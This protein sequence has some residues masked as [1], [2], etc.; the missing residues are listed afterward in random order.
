MCFRPSGILPV[1]DIFDAHAYPAPEIDF[2]YPG[3]NDYVKVIGEFGG[4]GWPVDGH[5][6]GDQKKKKFVY[7]EMPKTLAEY[8]ARYEKTLADLVALKAR[9]V[10][11]GVYTQTTDVE[12]EI[13]GLLTYDRKVAKISAERL[14]ELHQSLFP[15]AP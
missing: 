3:A 9:G 4:H 10:A 1:G 6:W 5:L 2:N 13:N 14:A 11:A 8:T 12:I 7:G 15:K